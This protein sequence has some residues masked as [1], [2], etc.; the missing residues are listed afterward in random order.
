MR[1]DVI[2]DINITDPIRYEE[3]KRQAASTVKLMEANVL[4]AV[5]RPKYSKEIGLLLAWSFFSWRGSI[6]RKTG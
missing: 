4:G 3:Y 2:V 6:R 1:A 5:A